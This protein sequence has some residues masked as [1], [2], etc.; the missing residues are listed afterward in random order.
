MLKE[1]SC[2]I[3]IYRKSKDGIKYLLLHYE[4]GHWDFPKGHQEK[5]ETEQRA[6]ER[7]LKEETGIEDVEFV[8][9][10]KHNINYYFKRG[11]E[12]AYKEVEFFLGR[13]QTEKI[14]L[15]DEHVGYSWASYNNAVKR[16]TFENAKELLSK[17]N[18]FLLKNS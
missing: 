13:T 7:E 17:A 18:N 10:F 5:N 9:D 16:L 14:M 3:I 12:T 4:E 15:S 6:A 11:D 2:G 8:N 1:K